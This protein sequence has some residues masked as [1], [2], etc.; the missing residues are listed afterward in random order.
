M[1]D[2]KLL[3]YVEYAQPIKITKLWYLVMSVFVETYKKPNNLN[4]F[5]Y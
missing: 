3:F 1:N 2:L 4:S 5:L